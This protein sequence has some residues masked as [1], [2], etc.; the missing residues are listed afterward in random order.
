MV[1]KM[2]KKLNNKGFSLVELIIVIAIMAILVGVLAPSLIKQLEKAKVS[3]DAQ[4]CDAVREAVVIALSTPEVMSDQAS[5]YWIGWFTSMNT[6]APDAQDADGFYMQFTCGD[7]VFKDIIIE[8]VGFDVFNQAERL[9]HL[10]S[11]NHNGDLYIYVTRENFYIGIKGSDKT[12][13]KLNGGLDITK[14]I[15]SPAKD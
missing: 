2:G 1:N 7:C 12:G 9:N 5:E 4:F 15:C 8:T 3:S 11:S 13:N 6:A 10:K 14:N